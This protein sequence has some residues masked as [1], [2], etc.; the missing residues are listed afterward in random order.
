MCSSDGEYS[1]V[2]DVTTPKARKEWRCD[3]CG[4][5]IPVGTIHQRVGS[6]Y[7][8][9]WSTL[10]THLG[11]EA[12]R[13]FVTERICRAEHDAEQTWKPPQWRERFQGSIFTGGLSE[14][15]SEVLGEYRHPATPEDIEDAKLLGIEIEDE[16]SP[17]D[18]AWKPGDVATWLWDFVKAEY[19]VE[20]A[21]NAIR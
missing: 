18:A 19:Q 15:I 2:W 6:L 13:E 5:P 14:E 11:C 4:L 3:E 16:D 10:R 12:V 20:G 8:G 9:S 17:E 21:A 7:D 1:A